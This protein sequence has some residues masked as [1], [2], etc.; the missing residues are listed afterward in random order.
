MFDEQVSVYGDSIAEFYDEFRGTHE[1]PGPAVGVLADLGSGGRV[2]ELG[3]GTGRV[4][5][6]LAARGIE[7]WGIDAS[8]KMV[9]QLRAKAGGADVPV[10]IGDFADV[11]VPGHFHLVFVALNTLVHLRDQ[12]SQVRCFEN[13]ARHLEP[14][15]AF[16]VEA[17]V[18]D[19]RMYD[20]DQR[21]NATEVESAKVWLTASRY[22]PR[23]QQVRG[24]H[25]LLTES[26]IR[27]CPVEARIVSHGELDL[28]ARLAGLRLEQRRGG[29]GAE[30]F[31]AQPGTLYVSVYRK[32]AA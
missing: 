16:V 31:T 26:G 3:I 4:A 19:I 23:T 7:V 17:R 20:Q 9:E 32:P 18:P 13:V 8:T 5:L 29:W 25:I 24:Q 21:V 15:G 2:L 22:D 30:P 11:D 27:F 28:M 12:E 14:S 6:P 1:D 10:I